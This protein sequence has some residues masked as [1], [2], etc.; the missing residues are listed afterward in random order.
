MSWS[1]PLPVRKGGVGRRNMPQSIRQVLPTSPEWQGQVDYC[2]ARSRLRANHSPPF[3]N[4]Q[5]KEKVNTATVKLEKCIF[6]GVVIFWGSCFP[7]RGGGNGPPV[8]CFA[9]RP[10]RFGLSLPCASKT[11]S[12]GYGL[13]LSPIF[14]KCEFSPRLGFHPS[15]TNSNLLCFFFVPLIIFLSF[16]D[17][18]R[19]F[20]IISQYG[21]SVGSV[22][23]LVGHCPWWRSRLCM[24][25]QSSAET[26]KRDGRRRYNFTDF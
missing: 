5:G 18:R 12:N 10:V 9:I 13:C 4:L 17:L 22:V 6:L 7:W 2:A 19:I 24:C 3:S 23:E 8:A 25:L 26:A 11:C 14:L 15:H 20:I 21:F 1:W 16:R